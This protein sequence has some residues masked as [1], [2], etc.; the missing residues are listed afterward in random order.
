MIY[1]PKED[2]HLMNRALKSICKIHCVS[3]KKILELGCGN[4]YNSFFCANKG[5]FV[6]ASDINYEAIKQGK[7]SAK[8]QNLKIEF[9]ESNMFENIKDNFFDLIFFNPPYLVSDNIE[10]ITVDGLEKGR[11][12]I[13]LFINQFAKH[14]SP[15]GIALLLHTD[16]N[17]L[18]E[19]KQKLKKQGF[20]ADII[21]QE[22][23]FFEELY[24]LKITKR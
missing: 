11:Y 17:D 16:Y 2:T 14:M 19:T 24:I 21:E 15:T 5:A 6:T 20:K 4:C 10:D 3:E 12:F 22:K 1:T 9:V 8:T 7:E 23:L 18:N 13:D